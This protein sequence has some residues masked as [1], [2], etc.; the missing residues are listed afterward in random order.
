MDQNIDLLR[1]ELRDWKSKIRQ[2]R[3]VQLGRKLSED[4]LSEKQR[5]RL[6]SY[7]KARKIYYL[8][9]HE[10]MLNYQRQHYEANR[11]K[12]IAYAIDYYHKNKDRIRARHKIL[13][14]KKTESLIKGRIEKLKAEHQK[15]IDELTNAKQQSV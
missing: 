4:E 11:D 5:L 14:A 2:L 8:K 10:K 15:I 13:W 3:P 9:N 12:K 6:E 7:R 1:A